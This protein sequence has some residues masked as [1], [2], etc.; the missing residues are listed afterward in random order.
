MTDYR[1]FLDSKRSYRPDAGLEISPD[2]LCSH[3]KPWQGD[4]VRYLLR[5]GCGAMFWEC[6]LGK[7]ISQ[8]EW[9]FQV[10]K[11][12]KGL[13]IILCPLSVARQTQR[14]AEKF[15][16]GRGWMPITVVKS[17]ADI[18]FTN[19][20]VITNYEKLSKFTAS[21]FSGVVL[22]ESSILKSFNG[23]TK[24]ALCDSFAETA[25]KLCCTATPAPND[26]LELGNHS[27]FLGVL[28][29]CEMISRWFINDSMNAGKYRLKGHA[30]GDYWDWVSSWA[31]SLETPADLGYPSDGYTLPPFE[32]IEHSV[33]VDDGPAPA[34]LLFPNE[35]VN[36]TS[37]HR[38]KRR[39]IEARAAKVR[40]IIYGESPLI[41]VVSR[42][43]GSNRQGKAKAVPAGV[44]SK[45]SPEVQA[46]SR[47]E[48]SEERSSQEKIRRGRRSSKSGEGHCQELATK[49]SA[50]SKAATSSEAQ[51]HV[52]GISEL[53]VLAEFSLQDLRILGHDESPSV[54]VCGSLP[55]NGEGSGDSLQHMQLRNQPVQ[56]LTG[57]S[58]VSD[59]VPPG[60]WVIWCDTDYEQDALEAILND[61]DFVSI[62]GSDSEFAKQT[63]EESWRFGEVRILLSKA[64]IF[65]HGLNWQHC[66]QTIFVGLSYSFE[67]FYQAIRRLWRFGQQSPVY[68]HVVNAPAEQVVWRTVKRKE[69]EHRLM[70][71]SMSG[72][73]LAA[74]ME[75]VRGKTRVESYRPESQIVLPDFLKA[76]A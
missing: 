66:H 64:E 17:Q 49:E 69:Q 12:T 61:G 5:R 38:E 39:S 41:K 3:L 20:I 19:G 45:E 35:S 72:A 51:D 34:G 67:R 1:T 15:Q 46:D 30:T 23:K 73:M 9:A 11:H 22:D 33:D 47:T 28:R 52:G 43:Q 54:S 36:A 70:K 63:R 57:A 59:I 76:R 74:Q 27:E 26:Q 40:E 18:S 14:E 31:V 24:Q 58:A 21:K 60:Q 6:G 32:I 55:Q 68:V 4:C 2:D 37:I 65:G 62:R 56:G 75:R 29:S 16:I 71:R 44:L 13:V 8:L 53:D 10:A 48:G 7:T 50:G 42:K 25:F